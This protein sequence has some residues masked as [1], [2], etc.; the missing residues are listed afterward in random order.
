MFRSVPLGKYWR[1]RPLVF[2]LLRAARRVRVGEVDLQAGLLLDPGVV[3]HLVALI[4][5]QR[6]TYLGRELAERGD[7]RVA[8]GHSG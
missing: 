6:P 5:G 7:E 8:D 2:S 4:P 1:S 3:E